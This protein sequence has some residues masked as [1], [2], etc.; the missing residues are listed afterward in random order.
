MQPGA[1]VSRGLSRAEPWPQRATQ[2]GNVTG[3][4]VLTLLEGSA[5]AAAET[6]AWPEAP[7]GQTVETKG[8]FAL[9][10][11]SRRLDAGVR[12]KALPIAGLTAV[13]LAKQSPGDSHTVAA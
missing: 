11:G 8:N 1:V 6:V 12:K 9:T 10:A 3:Q 4:I 13:T 5:L 2:A 7:Q